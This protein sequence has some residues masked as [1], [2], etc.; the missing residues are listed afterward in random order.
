MDITSLLIQ[1]VAGGAGGNL[2]GLLN[3]A[4]SLGPL[5]NTILGAVGGFGGGQVLGGAG[6]ALTNALGGNAMAG[7]AL[8]S[9]VGGIL[10][11]LIAG[12]L[13]KPTQA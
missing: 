7:T 2:A 8:S 10:I 13:K 12:F 1:L 9:A 4:R 11:P 3:K 5:L 6:G